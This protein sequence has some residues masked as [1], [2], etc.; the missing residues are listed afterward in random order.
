MKN[1]IIVIIALLFLQTEM[2]YAWDG[3]NYDDGNFVEIEKGNR[4][5][6]GSDIEVYNYG[7]GEYHDV[8]VE[9]ITRYGNSVELEVYNWDTGSYETYEMED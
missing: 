6:S 8:T 1:I 3:Y 4:V 9:S 7:S 2:S 5:R